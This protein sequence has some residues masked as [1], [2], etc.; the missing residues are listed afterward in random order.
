MCGRRSA[1]IRRSSSP[2][3][4]A[5]TGRSAA[6]RRRS[7]HRTLRLK[8]E[9]LGPLTLD[10]LAPGQWRYLTGAELERLRASVGLSA[11]R[12]AESRPAPP[13]GAH[14][15][16]GALRPYSTLQPWPKKRDPRADRCTADGPLA[17]R[18]ANGRRPPLRRSRQRV[19]A[20]RSPLACAR[21]E[22][23]FYGPGRAS[24]TPQNSFRERQENQDLR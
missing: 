12:S 18:P 22:R 10:G 9:R 5:A 7:A 4:R 23:C 21:P 13:P 8:R 15:A 1:A 14:P 16:R 2:S 11:G 19:A 20:A 6:W 17:P 3:A 24:A